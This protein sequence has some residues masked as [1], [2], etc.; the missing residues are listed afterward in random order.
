MPINNVDAAFHNLCKLCKLHCLAD[1]FNGIGNAD[2]KLTSGVCKTNWQQNTFI[3][4]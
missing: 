1:I 2:K 3:G 4:H